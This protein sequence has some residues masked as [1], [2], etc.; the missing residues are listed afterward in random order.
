M[1]EASWPLG[2]PGP[3]PRQ[4]P[5]SVILA[6]V[7]LLVAALFAL[8]ALVYFVA[9]LTRVDSLVD[10]AAQTTGAGSEEAE[11][12]RT[13]LKLFN[14]GGIAVCGLIAASFTGLGLWSARGGRAAQILAC[15]GAGA[16]ALFCCGCCGV[17]AYFA[18][19][20]TT[21]ET[22]F[23][24]ELARLQSEHGSWLYLLLLAAALLVPAC[25]TAAVVMLVLPPS[26]RFFRP[27]PAPSTSD[28]SPYYAYP[29][30]SYWTG[31]VPPPPP[32]QPPPPPAQPPPPPAPPPPP[33]VQ[34][35]PSGEDRDHPPPL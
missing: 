31:E 1:I 18:S 2:Q 8:L 22:E 29:D 4:R 11:S 17:S 25:A 6:L 32:A 26:N 19:Q 30:A 20:Q 23:D 34:P 27:P 28:W 35:P 24:T 7:L 16:T 21:D 5:W 14:G 12:A 15:I 10:Q 33:P 3:S 13:A 9:E